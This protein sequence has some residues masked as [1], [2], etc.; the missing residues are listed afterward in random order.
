MVNNVLKRRCLHLIASVEFSP[1]Q[2]GHEI[3]E[4]ARRDGQQHAQE[5]EAE[6]D[7]KQHRF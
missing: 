2:I 5:G 4:A 7:V 1:P 3:C 6:H